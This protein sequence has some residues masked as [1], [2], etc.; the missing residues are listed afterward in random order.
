MARRGLREWEGLP[1]NSVFLSHRSPPADADSGYAWAMRV[2]AI[3]IV[4]DI[5]GVDDLDQPGA[6]ECS[7]GVRVSGGRS[8][9]ELRARSAQELTHPA[10]SRRVI[11]T[12]GHAGLAAAMAAPTK[13]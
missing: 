4:G 13:C 5:V 12:S 7:P 6:V 2:N 11:H 9:A 3:G 1:P 8:L 10:R